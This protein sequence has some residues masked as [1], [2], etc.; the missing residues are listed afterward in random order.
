MGRGEEQ[1][2]APVADGG[3]ATSGT[4]DRTGTLWASTVI[5]L[6][7]PAVDAHAVALNSIYQYLFT[8]VVLKWLTVFFV[9]VKRSSF[10]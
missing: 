2:R 7:S 3:A 4:H 9:Y 10:F 5:S 8:G 6:Q 1:P